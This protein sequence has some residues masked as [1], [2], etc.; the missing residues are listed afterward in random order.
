MLLQTLLMAQDGKVFDNLVL[1]SKI[2]KMDRNYAIYLPSDYETANR[3]YPVLYLL[4]GS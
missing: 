1:P 3:S 2:L 4:H